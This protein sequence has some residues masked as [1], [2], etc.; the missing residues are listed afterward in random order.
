MKKYDVQGFIDNI[1]DNHNLDKFDE[2]EVGINRLQLNLNKRYYFK[3]NG[4]KYPFQDFSRKFKL[5]EYDKKTIKKPEASYKLALFR[6]LKLACSLDLTN[7]KLILAN[8][9]NRKLA[10][11][12]T[13]QENGTI[14]LIDYAQNMIMDKNDYYE[15]FEV[16]EINVLDKLDL[17]K[18]YTLL[19]EYD[20]YKNMLDYLLFTKE[21]FEELSSSEPILQDKYDKDGINY[22]NYSIIGNGHDSIFFQK[23]DFN[24]MKNKDLIERL[25]YFTAFPSKNHKDFRYIEDKN[26]FKYQDFKMNFTFKLLSDYLKGEKEKNKLLSSERYGHC[27]EDSDKTAMELIRAGYDNIYIVGGKVLDFIHHCWLE[28]EKP[29]E[30][31]VI[32]YTKN[33]VIEKSKYYKIYEA[34]M[35]NKTKAQDMEKIKDTIEPVIDLEFSP[36][37]YTFFGKEMMNDIKKN[38]KV[39]LRK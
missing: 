7:P 3:Y 16:K 17:Y 29:N 31:L 11:L 33:L 26:S 6:S 28:L 25:M 4:K 37:L 9:L 18:I 27:Y 24:G 12:I 39:L 2:I 38:E 8:T 13:Y 36:I 15:L 19:E 5:Q 20:D 1:E 23:H 34:V 35:I 21:K 30:T 14:K 10:S 32:D 22:G